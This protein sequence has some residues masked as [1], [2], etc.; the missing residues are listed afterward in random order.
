[1]T[2]SVT[3]SVTSSGLAVPA[4]A[5]DW[6]FAWW[7]PSDA[8]S[9]AA[10]QSAPAPAPTPADGVRADP[11]VT[12]EGGRGRT[13]SCEIGI[14]TD[15]ESPMMPTRA[16][17]GWSANRGGVGRRR[18]RFP[19]HLTHVLEER[20]RRRAQRAAMLNSARES[21]RSGPYVKGLD[22]LTLSL[23]RVGLG[24]PASGRRRSVGA[25]S[26]GTPT[27]VGTPTSSS[28]LTTCGTAHST[29]NSTA[30]SSNRPPDEHSVDG[31]SAFLRRDDEAQNDGDGD[32]GD[33]T[34]KGRGGR[35]RSLDA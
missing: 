2:P 17:G 3:P 1:M 30:N 27:S 15:D 21:G 18:I 26:N 8:A 25:L 34:T 33:G 32:G 6:W 13:S 23:T 7:Q 28:C 4:A 19:A 29:A 11:S 14:Q 16:R 24:L 31:S 9:S 20:E 35:D 5:V 12:A 22:D 10:A